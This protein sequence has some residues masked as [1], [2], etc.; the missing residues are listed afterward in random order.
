[1]SETIIVGVT[2]SPA[3]QRALDWAAHRAAADGADLLLSCIVGGAVGAVGEDD[4]L[5]RAM[6]AAAVLLDAEITRISALIPG[7]SI[8]T[9]VGSGNPTEELIEG[10]ADAGLLVIGIEPGARGRAGHH[11]ARIAAGAHCPVVVVPG[12]VDGEDRPVARRGVVVGVD[13]SDVAASA[14]AFAAAEASRLNEPLIAVSAWM[15]V[16][17]S[18]DFGMYPDMYT[19]NLQGITESLVA[20]MVEKVREAHPDL[21]VETRIEE[22]DPATVINAAAETALMTVIGTHGRSGIARFL[23]GSVSEEVLLHLKAPTAVVR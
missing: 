11:G 23:L 15:P 4:I 13:G 2:E 8:S 9:H 1:M 6:D 14:L 12:A 21:V 16:F 22:G 18:G 7:L 20:D 10:S 19:T 3:S 17:V 5:A